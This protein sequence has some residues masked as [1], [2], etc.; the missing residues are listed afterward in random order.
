M[1]LWTWV[2]V[3]DNLCGKSFSSLES[4]ITF[5]KIFKVISRP[6]FISDFNL[7]S[8]KTDNLRLKCYIE[9]F[10]LKAENKVRALLIFLVKNLKQKLECF[11]CSL[12]K[13]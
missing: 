9:S 4:P 10:Y 3:N 12:W 7:L 6:F 13:I 11:Y 8:W 2:L 5:D 1:K